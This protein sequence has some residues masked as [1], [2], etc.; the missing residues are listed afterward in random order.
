[1]VVAAFGVQHGCEGHGGATSV[2]EARRAVHGGPLAW[3]NLDHKGVSDSHANG[4][5]KIDRGTQV[6][7]FQ[8]I[9][10]ELTAAVQTQSTMVG[11]WGGALSAA[12]LGAVFAAGTAT[13]VGMPLT[14]VTV[15]RDESHG[16]R[17][18]ALSRY[19]RN[20]TAVLS[21]WLVGRVACTA[22]TAVLIGKAV[23]PWVGLWALPIAVLGTLATYGL[24]TE[25]STTLARRNLGRAAPVLLRVLY[26]FELLTIPMAWPMEFVGRISGRFMPQSED[27]RLTE[28][29]VG[30]LLA[31]GQ[32]DGTLEEERAQMI[33]NV[34]EFEDLMAAEVM[35]PRTSVTA[36]DANTTL[37]DVLRVI[38]AKGHSRYPVYRES[39]DNIVGL[40]YAKDLFRVIDNTDIRT[41]K[42]DGFIRSPVNFVPETK[43]VSALLREMRARRLHMAIVVDDY[44]GV[45][46]IVTLE[47]IIEEIIGDIQDEH[48]IEEYPIVE[49]EDGGVMVDAAVPVDDLNEFLGTTI[50]EEG[51][52]VSL[53]GWIIHEAGCVPEPGAE[54]EACGL[55][56]VVREADERKI[57]K[58]EIHRKD[59][60][61]VPPRAEMREQ[62]VSS[63]S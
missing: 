46:G 27:G 14:R 33:K 6:T 23:H 15:L 39:V 60:Q 20:P 5:A 13:L 21:R 35:I 19:L 54:L 63:P 36:I 17:R 10:E 8:Q 45:A 26:P 12:I 32:L 37:E 3:G 28:H 2:G 55:K 42:V 52:F 62:I 18:E 24:L 49:L 44:G 1:M 40:L 43:P 4:C 56:F 11:Y 30:L 41:S 57:S 61:T 16:R 47:D 29:E 48:D 38:S 31:E 58:V 25:I 7:L 34:L 51:D 59:G 53:G 22:L 50:P 9:T